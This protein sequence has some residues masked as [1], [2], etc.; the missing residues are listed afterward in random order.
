MRFPRSDGRLRVSQC[1]NT[2]CAGDGRPS[3]VTCVRGSRREAASA[4]SSNEPSSDKGTCSSM[5]ETKFV[6]SSAERKTKRGPQR[7]EETRRAP[8]VTSHDASSGVRRYGSYKPR[9]H[10]LKTAV[11]AAV[12]TTAAFRARQAIPGGKRARSTGGG[13]LEAPPPQPHLTSAPDLS[14]TMSA[15]DA[16]AARSAAGTGPTELVRATQQASS[17][18]DTPPVAKNRT[19]VGAPRR[20]AASAKDLTKARERSMASTTVA[21]TTPAP[22]RMM[23]RLAF[24]A[25]GSSAMQLSGIAA[26]EK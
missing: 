11:I 16:T 19:I 5:P 22:L 24:V 10:P 2:A 23:E 7:A 12:A 18:A 8:I 3:C 6:S 25:P 13:W 20:M 4:A 14:A 21:R 9:T 26:N 15:M 17:V 1:R